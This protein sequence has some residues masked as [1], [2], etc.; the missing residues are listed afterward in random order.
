MAMT[1]DD[2]LRDA[3]GLCQ[4]EHARWKH[5]DPKTGEH[6]KQVA[7]ALLAGQFEQ[8]FE[9]AKETVKTQIVKEAENELP[10]NVLQFVLD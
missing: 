6:W 1:F 7:D 10:G 8:A 3:I 4:S 2:A 5:A 9:R